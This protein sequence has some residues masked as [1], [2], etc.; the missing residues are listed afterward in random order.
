METRRSPEKLYNSCGDPVERREWCKLVSPLGRRCTRENECPRK[1]APDDTTPAYSDT[2]AKFSSQRSRENVHQPRIWAPNSLHFAHAVHFAHGGPSKTCCSAEL[3]CCWVSTEDLI[4]LIVTVL[5]TTLPDQDLPRRE[6]SVFRLTFHF[7]LVLSSTFCLSTEV[8][9]ILPS[10]IAVH[11]NCTQATLVQLTKLFQEP[12]FH[13][14]FILFSLQFR[15][16]LHTKNK[17]ETK[18]LITS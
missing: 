2:E 8:H 10:N 7:H 12:V 11:V 1:R 15:A 18:T 6:T 4:W 13:S 3:F 9:T 16:L 14:R 5:H 17:N